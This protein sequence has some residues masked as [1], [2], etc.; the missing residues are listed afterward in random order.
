M[1]HDTTNSAQPS[2]IMAGTQVLLELA[3][4]MLW[5]QLERVWGLGSE[6][7]YVAERSG[8]EN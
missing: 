8:R 4:L 7:R 6:L 3:E 2:T 5:V 1:P